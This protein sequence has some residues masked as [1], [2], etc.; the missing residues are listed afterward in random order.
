LSV[1]LRPLITA[2]PTNVSVRLGDN[3]TFTVSATGTGPL[4]Y[5]WQFNGT[6]IFGETANH[7]TRLNAQT[8]DAGNYSV[9]VSNVAGSVTSSNALLTVTVPQVLQFELI[10]ILPDQTVRLVL[11]GEVGS[12]YT[13]LSSSNLLDWTPLGTVS[14][15]NGTFE[16][17]DDPAT[18]GQ[19][20]YRATLAP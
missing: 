1:N 12:N 7:Y 5:Q 14:N 20:M 13:I 9:I 11:S 10:S 2:Q 4:S 17:I 15:T 3:A 8:N 19:R 18:N 16:F 6:D